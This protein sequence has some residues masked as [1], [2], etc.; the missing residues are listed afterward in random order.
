MGAYGTAAIKQDLERNGH[1]IVELERYAMANKIW[2]VKVK[3]LR[4]PDLLC[5]ECGRRFESKSKSVPSVKL[6]HSGSSGREW[7]AGGMRSDDVFAFIGVTVTAAAPTIG[8]PFYVTRASLEDAED[9]LKPGV[10]KA[11]ADGAEADV[12]WPAWAPSFSGTVVAIEKYPERVVRVENGKGRKFSKK[13]GNWTQFF[14]YVPVGGDFDANSTLVAGV[15][16]PAD[17]ACMGQ[18]DSWRAE[19]DAADPADLFCAVKA[20][21]T[22]RLT[23][24]EVGRV[25]EI[26]EDPET[27]WRLRLEAAGVLGRHGGD[28][29]TDFLER[30]AAN[31]T[32]KA[33]VAIEAVFILSELGSTASIESLARVARSTSIATDEVRAAAVWGIGQGIRAVQSLLLEFLADPSDLVALHAASALPAPLEMASVGHLQNL[34]ASGNDREMAVAAALLAHHGHLLELAGIAEQHGT[35]GALFALRAL[36]DVETT[37]VQAAVPFMSPEVHSALSTLWIQHDDWLRG[38]ATEGALTI[39]GSQ[40]VRFW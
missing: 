15:V 20:A 16:E 33:D 36:G 40:K 31:P 1:S 37:I 38:P 9:D 6:S 35:R 28:D 32:T 39:L 18:S 29:A 19:L 30:T 25:R 26:F 27:D 34:L 2:T 11:I 12:S 17:I 24:L 14:P 7:W 5:V 4:I 22:R 10:R 13:A 21:T 8:A 23:H 3:R